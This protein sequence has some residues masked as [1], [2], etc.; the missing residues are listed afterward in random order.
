MFV[1]GASSLCR[2]SRVTPLIC[3]WFYHTTHLCRVLEISVCRRQD[4]RKP[5]CAPEQPAEGLT[6]GLVRWRFQ[7]LFLGRTIMSLHGRPCLSNMPDDL[8]TVM[9]VGAVAYIQSL[10]CKLVCYTA[11][12]NPER[13]CTAVAYVLNR[14]HP[15]YIVRVLKVGDDCRARSTIPILVL[16]R[17]ASPL[18]GQLRARLNNS[19]TQRQRINRTS[20]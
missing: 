20:P 2:C 19:S 4:L 5:T 14:D 7:L 8:P 13:L 15:E 12:Q 18:V 6:R 16:F 10:I 11:F 3:I 17:I 9:D 1:A